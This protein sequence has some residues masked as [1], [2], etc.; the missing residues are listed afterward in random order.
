MKKKN[1]QHLELSIQLEGGIKK[2]KF[3]KEDGR[4][5]ETCDKWQ[6][7]C[8]KYIFLFF[9]RLVLVLLSEHV[10]R[11]NVVLSFKIPAGNKP[12]FAGWD[13]IM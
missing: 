8:D 11:F 4:W 10:K 6:V 13:Q 5:P 1:T 12:N 7:T 2:V 9:G 3:I